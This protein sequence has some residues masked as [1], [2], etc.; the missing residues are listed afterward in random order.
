ME[1]SIRLKFGKRLR[2]LR[3]KRKLTQDKLSELADIDYKY[4]QKIEGKNPPNIKLETIEKLAKT[5]KV[6]PSELLEP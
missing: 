1:L 3:N 5:L 6:K 4:L 2:E